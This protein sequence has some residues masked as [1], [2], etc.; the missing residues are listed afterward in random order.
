[1]SVPL[2]TRTTHQQ[3]ARPTLRDCLHIPEYCIFVCQV[4]MGLLEFQSE[5]SLM[6]DTMY[7]FVIYTHFCDI[8]PHSGHLA[9]PVFT[10]SN[11]SQIQ[12]RAWN[13]CDS[14]NYCEYI[15]AH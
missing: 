9:K 1:M 6:L 8:S 13:C 11:L 15:L 5:W 10:T 14:R 12:F 2:V 4:H 7:W 3:L